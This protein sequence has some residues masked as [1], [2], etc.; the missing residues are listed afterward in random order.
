[1]MC[2]MSFLE[3]CNYCKFKQKKKNKQ[4]ILIN[5]IKIYG[6]LS[7]FSYKYVIES[8]I[9]VKVVNWWLSMRFSWLNNTRGY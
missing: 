8:K 1:M 4:K 7:S 3:V 6:V 5:I 9:T 2:M